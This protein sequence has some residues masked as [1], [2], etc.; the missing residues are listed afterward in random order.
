MISLRPY[1]QQGLDSIIEAFTAGEEG[2]FYTLPTGGGKTVVFS[3][4]IKHYLKNECKFVVVAH[5]QELLKQAHYNIFKYTK[6]DA[7]II[8]A[9]NSDKPNSPIQLCMIQSLR[10]RELPFE[11]DYIITDEAHLCKAGSYV[12]FYEKY[13]Q[14][15][16]LYVSATPCR[17]DGKG[18]GDLASVLIKGLSIGEMIENGYLSPSRVFTASNVA[19]Q[20]KGIKKQAGDYAINALADMMQS[21]ELMGDI[22]KQY[23]KHA[24]GRKGVVFCVNVLHSIAVAKA[25]NDAGIVAEHLDGK[26][27]SEHREA[28]LE[29]LKTGETTIVTNCGILCEGWDE[30]SISYVGLAR[31][32][33]SLALYIQQAGRGLRLFE[34]KENCIILDH[35]N[36]TNEHGHIE[37][38]REWS[39]DGATKVSTYEETERGEKNRKPKECPNCGEWVD[40]NALECNCGYEFQPVK[41]IDVEMEEVKLDN[42]KNEIIKA[43]IEALIKCKKNGWL[44]GK[45][46]FELKENKD[47]D[48]K[49]VESILSEVKSKLI[50]KYYSR[51]EWIKDMIDNQGY[52]GFYYKDIIPLQ[53]KHFILTDPFKKTIFDVHKSFI[54]KKRN[55]QE[56][57]C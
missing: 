15:K 24:M 41:T 44:V 11:P 34:G 53:E 51:K 40:K 28:V 27:D 37:E 3:A 56:Q 32:T 19:S 29:R 22:V 39:L 10:S 50:T 18:F 57:P 21:V 52:I 1:Q 23:Q 46:F 7:G 9:S 12:D 20:L 16:K 33:K 5:R 17:A 14:A 38:C 43:Y 26:M 42:E 25:F 30:P 31:P 55:S 4:F 48:F 35:G 45:A 54:L 47:F 2:V 6:I 36:N 13:P 8:K 49:K